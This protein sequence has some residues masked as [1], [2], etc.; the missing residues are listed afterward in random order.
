MFVYIVIYC[1]FTKSLVVK[2]NIEGKHQKVDR[3]DTNLETVK[4]KFCLYART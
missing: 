3:D 4:H 1:Y 2:A